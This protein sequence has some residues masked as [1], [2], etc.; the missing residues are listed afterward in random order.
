VPSETA[1]IVQVPVS[2]PTRVL[3]HD[4]NFG[5]RVNNGNRP[6]D[7]ELDLRAE[8]ASFWNAMS[9]F[10]LPLL[11]HFA[12]F[13]T[14]EGVQRHCFLQGSDKG[15]RIAVVGATR[16][17]DKPAVTVRKHAIDAQGGIRKLLRPDCK[18]SSKTIPCHQFPQTFSERLGPR[19][20]SSA[21]SI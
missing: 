17:Q 10:A 1:V 13:A 16:S 18:E 14:E 9:P 19:C 7:E 6:S 8:L 2:P 21:L 15:V 11:L 3:T 20:S 12:E 5:E 4:F